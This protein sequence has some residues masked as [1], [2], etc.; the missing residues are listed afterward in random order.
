M[1]CKRGYTLL[2]VVIALG[3]WMV[4]VTSVL[5]VWHYT[6]LTTGR[7]ITRQN[8]FENARIAMDMMLANIQYADEVFIQ[9][10]M[11]KGDPNTLDTMRVSPTP[12]HFTFAFI[13]TTHLNEE[14]H[15]RLEFSGGGNE[16]ARFLA[17][18]VVYYIEG[19]RIEIIVT[20]TCDEP[21]VLQGSVCVR[22]K[23]VFWNE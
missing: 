13:N 11:Y 21:I 9:T 1:I 6:A 10:V 15:N 12:G 4:L 19:E 2:E 5:S 16:V 18:V 14:R 17:R 20:T 7:I 23:R 3:I 22:Y 8:A